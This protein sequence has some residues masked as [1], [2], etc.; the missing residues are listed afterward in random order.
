MPRKLNVYRNLLVFGFFVQQLDFEG[1]G[2][3]K[4]IYINNK[5]NKKIKEKNFRGKIVTY[6]MDNINWWKNDKYILVH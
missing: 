4:Y 1:K 5:P 3:Y 6:Y 2:R